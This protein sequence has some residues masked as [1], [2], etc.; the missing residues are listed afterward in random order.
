[1]PARAVLN[2]S[3]KASR[4]PN[5]ESMALDSAPD[6]GSPP[7]WF[8]GARFSQ[9]SVWFVCPPDSRKLLPNPPRICSLMEQ[10]VVGATAELTSVKVDERQQLNLR[11]DVAL[12]V[13]LCNLLAESVV[14]VDVGLVVHVVV[15]L[16]DL[17]GDGRLERAIVV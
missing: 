3:L 13:R 7:P 15:E 14:R 11:L 9:K 10:R 6:G 17:A 12:A 5:D 2:F 8:L 16:H 4:L 1:M